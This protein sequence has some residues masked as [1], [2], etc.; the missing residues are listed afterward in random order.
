MRSLT[1]MMMALAMTPLV[2]ACASTGSATRC[3]DLVEVR[4]G[5]RGALAIQLATVYVDDQAKA[6]RFYTE[7]L[8]F[9]TRD[10]VQ[11]GPYRWLTVAA[12]ADAGA[13]E[14]QL[15]AHDGPGAAAYQQAL[16][17]AGQPAVMLFTADLAA[18]HARL[19]ARGAVFTLPPSEVMPGVKIATLNDTCGN[20]VQL[21]ELAH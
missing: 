4:G 6:L 12:S 7:V 3:V 13:T 16:F 11:N 9:T 5:D 15:A 17:S 8:G 20:L 21:T 2:A 19:V 1:Q 14:L 18:T 10:D